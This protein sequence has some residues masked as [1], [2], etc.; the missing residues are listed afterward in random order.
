M[1]Q[2]QGLSPGLVKNVTNIAELAIKE[3]ASPLKTSIL[4]KIEP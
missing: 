3:A 4:V 2:S 1:N